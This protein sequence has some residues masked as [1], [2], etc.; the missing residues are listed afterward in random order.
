MR[1]RF[2]AVALV[3]FALA[4]LVAGTPTS[5]ATAGDPLRTLPTVHTDNWPDCC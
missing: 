5:A 1:A 3:I 2:Y 4:G